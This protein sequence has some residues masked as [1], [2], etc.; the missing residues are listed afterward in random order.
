MASELDR[1]SRVRPAHVAVGK[2]PWAGGP[3]RHTPWGAMAPLQGEKARGAILT[4][5]AKGIVV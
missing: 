1:L 3:L 5:L 4:P 2:F